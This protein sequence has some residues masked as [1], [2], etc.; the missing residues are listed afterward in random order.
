MAQNLR[1]RNFLKLI[2]FSSEEVR[3]LMELAK[4]FKSMKRAG[5]PHKVS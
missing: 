5:Q 1:G 3:Y 4:N 2:D